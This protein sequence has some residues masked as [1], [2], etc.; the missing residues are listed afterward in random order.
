MMIKADIAKTSPEEFY[1]KY[2]IQPILV[3]VE[4]S[5]HMKGEPMKRIMASLNALVNAPGEN[6]LMRKRTE[7]SLI[8]FNSQVSHVRQFTPFEEF[9][10]PELEAE[11]EA[12][13]NTAL[14]YALDF[15]DGRKKTYRSCG[16]RWS[17][18]L[19]LLFSSGNASDPGREAAA[20]SQ[21]RDA[22]EQKKLFLLSAVVGDY[23]DKEV[24]YRYYP[25]DDAWKPVASLREDLFRDFFSWENR[26]DLLFMDTPGET[27]LPQPIRGIEITI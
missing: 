22:I 23:A 5:L 12:V 6:V 24:L 11:G 10:V 25:T 15:L 2:G 7:I 8:C 17:R 20:V 13:L 3:L 21:M 9:T 27:L 14:A 1:D 16:I 26:P 19:L 18:P 4:T